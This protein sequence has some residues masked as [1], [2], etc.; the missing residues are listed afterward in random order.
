[1]SKFWRDAVLLTFSLSRSGLSILTTSAS[2]C[3]SRPS[4]V[5]V[6]L[7]RVVW[8]WSS[9]LQCGFASLVC[10]M[11][12]KFLLNSH[13]LSPI[14]MYLQGPQRRHSG[15]PSDHASEKVPF[16]VLI[17]VTLLSQHAGSRNSLLLP[18]FLRPRRNRRCPQASVYPFICE[19]VAALPLSLQCCSDNQ[20]MMAFCTFWN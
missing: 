17:L 18:V 15:E 7:R 19:P 10:R 5:T 20:Q 6:K 4:S 12:R 2:S 16:H 13:S 1:M 9:G 8:A 14:L 11:R 3:A